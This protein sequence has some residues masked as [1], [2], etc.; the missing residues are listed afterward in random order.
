MIFFSL[1]ISPFA[2]PCVWHT[3]DDGGEHESCDER[4]QHQV[5]QALQ[6]IITHSIQCLHIILHTTRKTITELHTNTAKS[7]II[8][9]LPSVTFFHQ[10]KHT[11]RIQVLNIT[12]MR[13]WQNYVHFWVNCH[14][15]CL[16][17]N[18]A[19]TQKPVSAG[20]VGNRYRRNEN[21]EEKT[22]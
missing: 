3:A 20:Y 4:E 6:S 14:F 13:K 16:A 17:C 12:R 22:L 2:M 10:R 1:Q 11:S 9:S 15:K 18:S 8:H 19:H 5:D 21:N 7:V